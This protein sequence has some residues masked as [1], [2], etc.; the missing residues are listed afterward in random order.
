MRGSLL[1]ASEVRQEITVQVRKI[2]VAA[3]SLPIRQEMNKALD[4]VLETGGGVGRGE[5]AVAM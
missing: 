2:K 4:S 1:E 3:L 5:C